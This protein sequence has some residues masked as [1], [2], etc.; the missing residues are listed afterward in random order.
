VKA[1][2]GWVVGYGCQSARRLVKIAVTEKPIIRTPATTYAAIE[3]PTCGESQRVEVQP[4]LRRES[5]DCDSSVSSLE[6]TT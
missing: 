4:R 1:P 3:C 6:T 5:E 2:H